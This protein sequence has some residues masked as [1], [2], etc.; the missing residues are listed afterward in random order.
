[1]KPSKATL[2]IAIVCTLLLLRVIFY[3]PWNY[4]SY[5][6]IEHLEHAFLFACPTNCRVC[7]SILL[8]EISGILCAG[9]LAWLIVKLV[10]SRKGDNP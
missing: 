3:P 2:I 7:V 10:A 4:T 9:T 5:A 6:G 8:L 1:M